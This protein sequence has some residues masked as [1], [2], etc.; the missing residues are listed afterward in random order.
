[1]SVLTF[2]EIRQELSVIDRRTRQEFVKAFLYLKE[3]G[4]LKENHLEN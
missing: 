1:M 4:K 2:L 3:A